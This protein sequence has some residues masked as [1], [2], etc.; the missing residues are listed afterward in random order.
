MY[1]THNQKLGE[2]GF[3][4]LRKAST[5]IAST[6]GVKLKT[7]FVSKK[8]Q[9]CPALKK[10]IFWQKARFNEASVIIRNALIQIVL[11]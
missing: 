8:A 7:N 1:K 10:V 6:R 4:K 5:S 3:E 9:F 11:L 2:F